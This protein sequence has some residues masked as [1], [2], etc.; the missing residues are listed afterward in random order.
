MPDKVI[1]VS[2]CDNE[3]RQIQVLVKNAKQAVE[4]LYWPHADDWR[5]GYTA[6]LG[7]KWA[8][9]PTYQ[10]QDPAVI[11]DVCLLLGL[12]EMRALRDRAVEVVRLME[13]AMVDDE[14]GEPDD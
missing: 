14:G 10:R 9:I 12:D 7:L 8:T 3:W 4:L 11:P 13:E 1:G 6:R 5:E 2:H